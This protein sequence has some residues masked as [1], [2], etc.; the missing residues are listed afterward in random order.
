MVLNG[1]DR[2]DSYTDIFRGKRIG[3]ICSPSG[4]NAEFDSAID[5]LHSRFR[6]SAL[7]SPEHG[8]RG[9]MGA[10]DVVDTYTD[11]KINVPVY[12]LYRSDSKRLTDEM[13]H[14]I[15]LVAY[16]IQ[17][18]GARYYTFIY[19]ML[20]AMQECAKR[21]IEFVVFDR[22]D[23]LGGNVA[24]GNV[25]KENYQSF[26]GG[27]PLCM[28][29]ALTI[30]EFA[31][32]A[33]QEL[34]LGCRLHVIRCSGWKREM[35]F[36]D[37]GRIWVMPSPGLPRFEAALLYP[38]TCFFE[39]TNISEGRGTSTPFEVFG[40]P[41]ID[42]DALAHRL[43]ALDLPGV[44]FRP[45][46]FIPS[47][48]K[49]KGEQCGGVQIHVTEPHAVRAVEIGLNLIFTIQETAGEQF[50]FLPAES[51]GGRPVI[52]LLT[53]GSALREGT[54]RVSDLIGQYRTESAGFCERKKEFHLY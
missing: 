23:P 4:V 10:G 46:F 29:Y 19:T 9:D 35:L 5:I 7:Y 34:S 39:G 49:F 15:D 18:V 43:N 16:D 45:V 33:N 13:L 44:R 14:N 47:A 1:I 41:F 53:G 30:G 3:L 31:R 26:I 12:S 40:A 24:E 17:D 48:S 25:I 51:D 50:R 8:V 32:M 52:D 28:R 20:Y 2:I 11:P 42:G 22:L 54:A 21:G 27:Y 37:T 38:G 36:S 6:L